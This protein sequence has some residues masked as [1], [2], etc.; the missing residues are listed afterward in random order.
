MLLSYLIKYKG[1]ISVIAGLAT[2]A[3]GYYSLREYHI[4][5]GYDKAVKELQTSANKEIV[6]ATE[7]AIN[8]A[9]KALVKQQ[10]I[11]D[12]EL[13]RVKRERI[14]ETKTKEVIKYVDKIQIRDECLVVT[15][16]IMGLLNESIST[17]NSTT[18][19]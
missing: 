1:V 19:N 14:V 12:S 16:D 8:D 7:K 17:A 11:F 5:V 6:K 18:K 3:A 13:A 10:G 15:D 2:V 9:N 4:G